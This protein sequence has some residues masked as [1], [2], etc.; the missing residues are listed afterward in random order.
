MQLVFDSYLLMP[1]DGEVSMLEARDALLA[2]D[3]LRFGGDNQAELW[4][5]FARRGFGSGASSTN[6]ADAGDIGGDTDD[7]QPEA[8]FSSPLRSDETTL[9]F[10]PTAD[11]TGVPVEAELYVGDY[12]ANVTPVADTDPATARD[13]QVQ[14]LPGTYSFVAR[15]DG[16]GAQK[17]SQTIGAGQALDLN[18]A[19]PTNRASNSSGAVTTDGDPDG[20]NPDSLTDDTE[21]TNWAAIER[22]PD[23]A[24]AD[25][26]VDLAGGE[27]LVDRVNVSALLRDPDQDGDDQDDPESQNRFTALRQFELQACTGATADC[28]EP[29]EFT[30]FYTSSAD[31]FP[32]DVPRPLAPDMNLRSFNVP[33]TQATHLRFV[34]VTNQCLGKAL[35]QD[36]ALDNDPASNSDCRLG[37][38]P[39][40]APTDNTVRAAELQ[41][42]SSAASSSLTPTEIPEEPGEEPG[43]DG[44][45]DGGGPDQGPGGCGA[46]QN[47]SNAADKLAGT[48]A[49]D[50]LRGR[51]GRDRLNGRGGDDCLR[52]G[53]DRDRLRGGAGGDL[54]A[55]G[56]GPDRIKGGGGADLVRAARGRA[57][58]IDCGPGKDRALIG[59]GDRTK[60]CEK[61]RRR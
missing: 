2:A 47:G 24:G 16:F 55:G 45:G 10:K 54:L 52:G 30:S 14:L 46:V 50:L 18:V 26:L 44:G 19:M 35:F 38:P 28:D 17:L 58:R 20:V 33:D 5:A 3:M 22:D 27:Q 61:I 9:R 8:S 23:A 43:G 60:R 42:F 57:D 29:G 7:P 37:N 12:E 4:D 59:R 48:D 6:P 34:V 40:I 53:R 49:G 51:G 25:V 39:T 21:V 13:D 41:V 36:N 31:A 32:G 1:P 11:Q 56:R 15:G